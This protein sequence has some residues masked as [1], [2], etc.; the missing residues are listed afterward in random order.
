MKEV[1]FATTNKGKYLSA[2]RALAKYKIKVLHAEIELP[3]SQSSL[4]NIAIHKAKFAYRFLKRP[5][6]AMDAGFFIHSLNGFPM[7]YVKSALQTIGIRGIL[8]LTEGERR[9]CE[10][11]EVLSFADSLHSEPKIFVRVVKGLLAKDISGKMSDKHWSELALVFIPE[12]E[13]KTMADM[14]EGE[15]AAFRKRFEKDS[16]FE[17]FGKY[18]SEL[19]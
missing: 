5:V 4:E 19:E 11:R 1:T 3:E 9:E 15:Y 13:T 14:D 18:Y 6:I 8:K 7:M 17:Q 12:N 16:H 10:F 2:K